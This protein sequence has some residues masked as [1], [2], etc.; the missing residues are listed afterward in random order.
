[1]KRS[2]LMLLVIGAAI[3]FFGCEKMDPV[4]PDFELANQENTSLKCTKVKTAFTGTSTPVINPID[5]GTT[6]ILPNGKTQVMGC[7]AE[8]YD[9][10]SDPR[11]TGTSIWYENFIW[12]AEPFASPGK[13]WGKA[14]IF[15]GGNAEENDGRWEITW[16]GYFTLSEVPGHFTVDVDAV[17]TGKEGE[18]KG[19]T[20][21]WKYT[22]DSQVGFFYSTEGYIK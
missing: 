3:F 11:V 16:H 20:A 21:K 10:A 9:Q 2:K 14:E 7:V 1:M 22:F 13:I 12:D 15:V 6:K 8:W 17:G 19:L 18:V 4:P 5:P